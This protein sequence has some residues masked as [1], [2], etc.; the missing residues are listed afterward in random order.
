MTDKEALR[1]ALEALKNGIDGQTSTEMD[2][3]ITAIKQALETPVQ[4]R[5]QN[6]GTGYCSC[7][8]CVMEPA[9]VQ[10]S[11]KQGWDVDTLLDKPA[12]QRP[13][14]GLTE[15]EKQEW[16]DAMPYDI[17]PRHCMIL[18]NVME[19]KLKEKNT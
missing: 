15:Q 13:F 9:P 18:V 14:V 10:P 7:V 2:K 3:A 8:E 12:A 19:A 4:K 11:I 17:E 1:M 6:C 5:P 16:I